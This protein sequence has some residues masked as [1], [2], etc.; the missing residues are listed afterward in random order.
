MSRLETSRLLLRPSEEDDIPALLPL[1]GDIDVA[2]NLSRVPHPYGEPDA[3]A[4]LALA[5]EQRLAGTDFNFAIVRKADGVYMGGCGL[6]LRGGEWEF[7]YWLG[8]PYWGLGYATEA[9]RRL[10]AH[11]FGILRLEQLIAVYFHDNPASGRVLAKLGCVPD[12]VGE[13]DCLAR[14]HAVYCHN[15]ILDREKFERASP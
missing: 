11:A 15:V 1:I 10:L 5:R 7:G 3:H 2:R 8:K 6:H 9:A 13:R 14:G 4:Y 12:G